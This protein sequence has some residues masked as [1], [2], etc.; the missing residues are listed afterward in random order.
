MIY[1]KN[2][3]DKKNKYDLLILVFGPLFLISYFL[4]DW[5]WDKFW[6]LAIAILGFLAMASIA[7]FMLCI[8][9]KTRLGILVGLGIIT[10][11]TISEIA[12]SEFFKSERILQATLMDNRSAIRL[13]LRADHKF[14]MVAENII[15]EERF[16]GNYKLIGNKIIFLDK[17]FSNEMMPDTLTIIGNKVIIHFNENGIPDTSFATYFGIER[18]KINNYQQNE[19]Q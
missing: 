11:V 18:N 12:T 5:L 3:T 8:I 15:T 14:E 4:F 6:F 7:F 1:N 2:M 10:A 19:K 9:N 17:H 16:K 13:T